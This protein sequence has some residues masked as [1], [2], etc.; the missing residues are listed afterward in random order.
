MLRTPLTR[1]AEFIFILSKTNTHCYASHLKHQGADPFLYDLLP[2][3]QASCHCQ[4]NRPC[5]SVYGQTQNSLR[6]SDNVACQ[7]FL[8]LS[9]SLQCSTE[10]TLIVFP[11][12]IV[13]RSIKCRTIRNTKVDH[14]LLCG[15]KYGDYKRQ[16]A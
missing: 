9:K 14:N 3:E 8:S 5:V 10:Q 16:I 13:K 15:L 4:G 7:S 1:S 2:P 12:F 11:E 6:T